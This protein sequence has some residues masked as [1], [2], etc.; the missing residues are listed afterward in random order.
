MLVCCVGCVQFLI[1]STRLITLRNRFCGI[2]S[3][4]RQRLSS[5]FRIVWRY[6]HTPFVLYKLEEK[7]TS[8]CGR[9]ENQMSA[10]SIL[11]S[12]K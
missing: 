5:S 12:S 9:V 11:S 6:L 4:K 2:L 10:T 3:I 7:S 1:L 8:L